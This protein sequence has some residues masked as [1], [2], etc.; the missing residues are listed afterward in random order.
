[1]VINQMFHK[2]DLVSPNDSETEN[3]TDHDRT[4]FKGKLAIQIVEKFTCP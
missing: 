1:M 2:H 4:L 3:R